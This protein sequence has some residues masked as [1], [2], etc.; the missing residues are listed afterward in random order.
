[1]SRSYPHRIRPNGGAPNGRR[2]RRLPR[3]TGFPPCPGIRPSPHAP[4]MPNRAGAS[5][6]ITKSSKGNPGLSH[7]EGRLAWLSPSCRA[8]HR[9]LRIL[10]PGTGRD[11]PL[12]LKAAPDA[13]PARRLPAP[14][15]RRPVPDAT[16]ETRSRRSGNAPPPRAQ[17]PSRDVHAVSRRPGHLQQDCVYDPVKLGLL[18]LELRVI[19]WA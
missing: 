10:A 6:G 18:A 3:K 8:L 1:M 15:R 14:G 4:V 17:N 5:N 16:P 19:P 2:E 11:S 7:Y 13:S 9:R 12:G